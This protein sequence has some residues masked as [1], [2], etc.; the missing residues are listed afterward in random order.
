MVYKG[1]IVH[2][3]C[4]ILNCLLDS[5]PQSPYNP[6]RL[7]STAYRHFMIPPT[8]CNAVCMFFGPRIRFADA[9][10]VDAHLVGETLS[11]SSSE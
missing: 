1:Q 4:G 8:S 9:L 6:I 7:I 11:D 2:N 3:A 5:V 10:N